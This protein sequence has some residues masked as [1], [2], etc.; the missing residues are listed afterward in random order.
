EDPTPGK[1]RVRTAVH[2]PRD[3]AQPVDSAAI[4]LGDLVVH[5]VHFGDG[6]GWLLGVEPDLLEDILV[7]IEAEVRVRASGQRPDL[8]VID[9]LVPRGRPEVLGFDPGG[10]NLV[11]ERFEHAARGPFGYLRPVDPDDIWRRA[12]GDRREELGVAGGV[13]G[14]KDRL[15]TG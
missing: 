7:P 9:R 3:I 4:D 6:L 10:V 1:H 8:V 14:S 13:V 2:D 12:A 15:D 11:V 5:L